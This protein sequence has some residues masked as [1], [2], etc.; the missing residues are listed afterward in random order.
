[1]FKV[2]KLSFDITLTAAFVSSVSLLRF[3]IKRNSKEKT[4]R[5]R[6]LFL[7][8]IHQFQLIS[9]VELQGHKSTENL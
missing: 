6:N 1:M 9:D 8:D 7:I 4:V 5:D 3:V 2:G